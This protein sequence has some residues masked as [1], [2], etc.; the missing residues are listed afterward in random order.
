MRHV[1]TVEMHRARKSAPKSARSAL[2]YGRYPCI[3]SVPAAMAQLRGIQAK[4]PV[5]MHQVILADAAETGVAIIA[6]AE[7]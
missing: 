1:M 6:S 5:K 4:A 7:A 3:S 2:R